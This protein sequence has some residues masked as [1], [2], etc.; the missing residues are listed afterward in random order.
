[1]QNSTPIMFITWLKRILGIIRPS[2]KGGETQLSQSLQK[3]NKRK[4]S[5]LR[6]KEA[7]KGSNIDW[8]KISSP[9][10]TKRPAYSIFQAYRFSTVLSLTGL[11]EKRIKEEAEKLK[12]LEKRVTD[13]LSDIDFLIK[14]RKAKEAQDKL[15]IAFEEIAQ[16]KD[17]SIKQ[18]LK[19]LQRSLDI[20]LTEIKQEELNRLIEEQRK[21]Q[22]EA[23]IQKEAK[24]RE[25][26]ERERQE[27]KEEERRA[28]E[29]K[30]FAE[31][32]RQK[33]EAERQERLR[34]EN[35]SSQLKDDWQDFKNVLNENDIKY[36]YHFTD[37][38][39]I[40]S[41]KQH[42]GLY[43]WYY[44]HTHH[45]TI[46][47]PGGDEQSR[48]RDTLYGL[49]DYVRLSFCDDHPMA[50]KLEKKGCSIRLL[51]I[52]AEVALLKDVQFS[53]MNAA[54]K[55]HIHGKTIEYLQTVD[56][57]ATRMHYLRNTDPNFKKHQAE[58]MVKTFIPLKYIENL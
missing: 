45:I 35:L 12:S 51:K 37:A 18:R 44:C 42:G 11:K 50:H 9:N 27:R 31:E 32:A 3:L 29:A 8:Y 55:R 5:I 20:L 1:M 19:N 21:K 54:D 43:S 15:N 52:K 26:K 41:I 56:F 47:H 53:N 30:R 36:L 25:L 22:E 13:L 2:N 6:E 39:N 33:E 4:K 38:R 10:H 40:N 48:N 17:P 58:V 7:I 14:E 57:D 46:P 28:A 23:R 16:I 24:E 34:L 49:E